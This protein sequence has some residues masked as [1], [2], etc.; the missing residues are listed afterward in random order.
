MVR[1]ISDYN[2]LEEGDRVL[3]AISGGKDS[4]VMFLKLLDIREK[5]KFNFT[6]H[7]LMLDQKQPWFNPRAYLKWINKRGLEVSI[8][9]ENIYPV[10]LQKTKPGKSLCRICSRLRRGALYSYAASNGYNKIALGHHRDDL[11]ETVLLNMFF[12]GHIA[13]MPPK[14]ISEDGRNI[15]IRP[16]CYIEEKKIIEYAKSLGIPAMTCQPCEARGSMQRMKIKIL[17]EKLEKENP[18]VGASILESLKNIKPSQLMDKALWSF[19]KKG[20][21]EP[22]SL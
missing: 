9:E 6:I 10:A 22:G 5:A 15:V 18:G 3:C 4:T 13:S 2:M 1:G 21:K 14:L 16:M 20:S 8:L 17:L 7:G 11:N 19:E 12:S